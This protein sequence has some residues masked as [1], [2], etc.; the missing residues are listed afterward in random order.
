MIELRL[1]LVNNIEKKFIPTKKEFLEKYLD[2]LIKIEE[3]E[4]IQTYKENIKYRCYIDDGKCK[5]TRNIKKEKVTDVKE[6]SKEDFDK[7][8]KEN[9]NNCIQKIRKYYIDGN[10]EIDVDYFLKPIN[11]IMVEVESKNDSLDNYKP[12]IGF[13]DVTKEQIY[14]N[15]EIFNGSIISNNTILEGTDGVGKTTTII[16]L[17][18]EGIICQDRCMDMISKNMLFDIPI[19]KRVNK[20]QNYLKNID[21][22]IIILVNNDKKELEKRINQRKVLS[23]FDSLAYEYNKLYVETYNYMKKH[24]MLENKMFM[25]DCTGLSIEEQTNAIKKIILSKNKK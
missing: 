2:S 4:I 1:G 23:E 13:I 25:V 22:N 14:E 5:Y 19:D 17:L 6:I 18:K 9:H 20:Y 10:F 8:L 21:K 11:M 3:Y 15:K 24:N 7:I 16:E 12:P